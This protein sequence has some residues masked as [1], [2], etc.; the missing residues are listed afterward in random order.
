[1]LRLY[2][3]C[4]HTLPL[5]RCD[6]FSTSIRSEP[7]WR[8]RALGGSCGGCCR[9]DS[10]FRF[11]L[12]DARKCRLQ[13]RRAAPWGLTVQRIGKR[14][15]VRRIGIL[16][17]VTI[18]GALNGCDGA[19][20]ADATTLKSAGAPTPC[21]PVSTYVARVRQAFG[22]YHDA[23]LSLVQDI[24]LARFMLL[25]ITSPDYAKWDAADSTAAQRESEFSVLARLKGSYQDALACHTQ[26]D[27]KE[28]QPYL[29]ALTNLE[30]ADNLIFQARGE[31]IAKCNSE[32]PAYA[33]YLHASDQAV[34]MARKDI[35]GTIKAELPSDYLTDMPN[36]LANMHEIKRV[37]DQ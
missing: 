37:C 12:G 6:F 35:S 8:V 34:A 33:P 7:I 19:P 3:C 21:T 28:L 17:V 23:T 2:A 27:A 36:E 4:S 1:M 5:R 13:R 14:E 10:L 29:F 22:A 32:V 31:L 25:P 9:L 26:A 30:I 16:V 24:R 18:A 15:I 11:D 20:S